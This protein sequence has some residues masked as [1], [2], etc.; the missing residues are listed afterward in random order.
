MGLS[1]LFAGTWRDDTPRLSLPVWKVT[2]V[3]DNDVA[4]L[5]SSLWS[6][7]TLGRNNLSSEWSLV[8]VNV[9]RDSRLVKVRFCL[10]EVLCSKVGAV[11][12]RSGRR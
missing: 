12:K 2:L 5:T 3:V 7:N 8:L 4:S 1:V 11:K 6:N 10:K 9:D